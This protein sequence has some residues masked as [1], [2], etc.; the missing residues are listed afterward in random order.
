MTET[1]T[2]KGRNNEQMWK[3]ERKIKW[4]LRRR[5]PRKCLLFS[6]CD[7]AVDYFVM[8][9]WEEGF[10]RDGKYVMNVRLIQAEYVEF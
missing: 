7:L 8:M 3:L 9:K 1:N 6:R 4:I 2:V 10:H 5:L